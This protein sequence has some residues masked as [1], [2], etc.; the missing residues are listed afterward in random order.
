MTETNNMPKPVIAVGTLGGTITMTASQ[1]GEGVQST[2][3]AEQL[4]NAI[5]GLDR[6]GVELRLQTLANMA[7]GSIRFADLFRVLQWA[8]AQV[9][10]GAAGVVVVQGTDTLEESAFFL[11][12]YWPYAEPLVLTGAMRS[13]AQAGAEGSANLLA[14]VQV[15]YSYAARHY[16]AVV[17]MNDEIHEARLVRKVHTTALNAF[18]SPVQGPV[19][20]VREGQARF[21]RPAHP[22]KLLDIPA[23][24]LDAAQDADLAQQLNAS[25]SVLLLETSL[26]ENPIIYTRLAELGYAGLVVA[27]LGSGHVSIPVRDALTDVASQ[28]PVLMASRTGAGSTARAVYAYPGSEI[29]LQQRGVMMVGSLCP[30]KTRL[31]L[32]AYLWQNLTHT[33]LLQ[34][35]SEHLAHYDSI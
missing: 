5:P 11:D 25:G 20:A 3:G 24:V 23:V 34:A 4:M 21:F 22:R 26:D 1:P 13:P 19:G 9:E 10:Q 2:L 28:M 14:A 7:S 32:C 30:R 17:V 29:D 18:A 31:L 8:S 33:E 16:G 27:G 12:L 15:A 6:V 35:L